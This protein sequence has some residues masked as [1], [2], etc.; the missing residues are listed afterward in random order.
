MV[1]ETPCIPYICKFLILA[2]AW[3]LD[4]LFYLFK[5]IY[6]YIHPIYTYIPSPLKPYIY[7]FPEKKQLSPHRFL[8]VSP[9]FQGTHL[10]RKARPRPQS[11]D[12]RTWM[13]V[14]WVFHQWFPHGI[15]ASHNWIMD[16]LGSPVVSLGISHKPR[17]PI[18]ET[19][20]LW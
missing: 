20:I 18:W 17:R 19:C 16:F 4:Y 11:H 15:F 14:R 8:R 5:Y 3:F 2:K 7:T 10:L 1:V 9:G 12:L 13:K 6:I